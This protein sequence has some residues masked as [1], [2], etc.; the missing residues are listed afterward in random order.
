MGYGLARTRPHATTTITV[1]R[2]RAITTNSGA[3]TVKEAA[4][5]HATDGGGGGAVG[6]LKML[7]M[8]RL[9]R[10]IKLTRSV[11]GRVGEWV[12]GR[13]SGWAGEWVSGRVGEWASE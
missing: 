11:G 2:Y 6:Q 12:G 3:L 8:V 13:A 1:H 10:L 9:L 5:L 4:I 7:R